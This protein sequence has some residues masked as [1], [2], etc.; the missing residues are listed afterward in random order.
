MWFTVCRFHMWILF[1][2]F[3]F[4]T[5]SRVSNVLCVSTVLSRPPLYIISTCVYSMISENLDLWVF[6]KTAIFKVAFVIF[7]LLEL[8]IQICFFWTRDATFLFDVLIWL[9]TMKRSI[10]R[11]RFSSGLYS[12][13]YS[14]FT[15]PNR[16]QLEPHATRRRFKLRITTMDRNVT[17]TWL[18]LTIKSNIMFDVVM[19]KFVCFRLERS[20]T[21]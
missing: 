20:R 16:L 10:E 1:V 21:F 17:G 15:T 14:N 4:D 13:G 5:K 12:S 8:L 18:H 19:F 11:K 2:L 9:H 3:P 7:A 6:I